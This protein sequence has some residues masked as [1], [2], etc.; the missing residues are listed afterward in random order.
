M[1]YNYNNRVFLIGKYRWC[2]KSAK[3]LVGR[4]TDV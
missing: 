2:D 4:K 1:I 3:R